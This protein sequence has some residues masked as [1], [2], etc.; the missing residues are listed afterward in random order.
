MLTHNRE[1]AGETV[2]ANPL[3]SSSQNDDGPAPSRGF[4]SLDVADLDIDENEDFGGLMVCFMIFYVVT[5]H[6]SQIL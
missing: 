5:T 2:A 3:A 1:K 6:Y 4:G